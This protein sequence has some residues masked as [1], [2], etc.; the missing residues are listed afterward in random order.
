[1]AFS[2]FSAKL[3]FRRQLLLGSKD[4]TPCIRKGKQLMCT[5]VLFIAVCSAVTVAKPGKSYTII[6]DMSFG[7]PANTCFI[8]IL[9]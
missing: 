7:I 4:L 6:A 9:S 5:G 3:S 2:H 8:H 1:M